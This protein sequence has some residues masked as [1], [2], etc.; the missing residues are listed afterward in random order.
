MLLLFC[1]LPSLRADGARGGGGG[2]AHAATQ[3]R[4][5]FDDEKLREG[6]SRDDVSHKDLVS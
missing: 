5:M 2:G 3:V 4:M 6:V 1:L